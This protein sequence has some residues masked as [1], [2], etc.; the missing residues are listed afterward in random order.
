MAYDVRVIRFIKATKDLPIQEC[1][2]AQYVCLG[3]FDMFSID[4]LDTENADSPLDA[5][6]KDRQ[7]DGEQAYGVIAP[8]VYSL[9]VLRNVAEHEKQ[10]L[11]SFWECKTVYTAVTRIHSDAPTNV[12]C[13]MTSS[14]LQNRCKQGLDSPTISLVSDNP[15]SSSPVVE[16]CGAVAGDSL[17]T[18]QGELVKCLFY[19]SLELG[20]AVAILKGNCLSAI[21]EVV[22]AFS[23]IPQVRDTYTYCG[24]FKDCLT[25]CD[26]PVPPE[27]ALL[28]TVNTRFSVRNNLKAKEYFDRLKE[29]LGISLDGQEFY[30]TGTAD[31]SIYWGPCSEAHLLEIIKHIVSTGKEMHDCFND[32]ITRIGLPYQ[33]PTNGQQNDCSRV[34]LKV[35]YYREMQTIWNGNSVPGWSYPLRKLLG[36]LSAMEKNYVMDDLAKLL[37]PSVNAFL[38]QLKSFGKRV[39]CLEKWEQDGVNEFLGAWANLSGDISQLES[40]L[41]QHPELVP[42]RYYIPAILL[43]F[44]LKILEKCSIA[45]S[46]QGKRTFHPLLV[47]TDEYNMYTVCPL[48]PGASQYDGECPLLVFLPVHDLYNPWETILRATHEMAHYCEDESRSRDDRHNMLIK[49]TARYIMDSWYY[50]LAVDADDSKHTLYQL[51]KSSLDSLETEI[52]SCV[53]NFFRSHGMEDDANHLTRSIESLRAAGYAV[54]EDETFLERFLLKLSPQLLYSQLDH[55]SILNFNLLYKLDRRLETLRHLCA[56]CYADVAMVLLLQIEPVDYYNSIYQAEYK[57]LNRDFYADDPKSPNIALHIER[58]ALVFSTMNRLMSTDSGGSEATAK[59]VWHMQG[60]S[61]FTHQDCPWAKR[62]MQVQAWADTSEEVF[63]GNPLCPQRA[64]ER[65]EVLDKGTYE[66]LQSYLLLCAKELHKKIESAVAERQE[67]IQSIRNNISCVSR[68][69]FDWGMLQD[70]LA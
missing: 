20:D 27:K 10:F 25:T 52:G 48:D 33:S 40:Q 24:V 13:R 8:C 51:W 45:L 60:P 54:L 4:S 44:E 6:Q 19:D 37:I 41:T 42:V 26:H 56:E 30:V 16:I 34:M 63:G 21:L 70:F 49:C 61:P 53:K 38:G 31:H 9:Y 39:V 55:I 35:E 14:T 17:T 68:Q 69:N 64:D 46:D 58:M 5:I 57:R 67:A 66:L 22:R 11:Q 29:E 2:L 50:D 23:T 32:V 15:T 43:Q 47:T 3:H 36:V 12:V 59:P 18:G 28:H 7:D 1:K 65:P 62:A